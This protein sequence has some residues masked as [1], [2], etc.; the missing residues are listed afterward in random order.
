MKL[1]NNLK[2]CIFPFIAIAVVFFAGCESDHKSSPH[3]P[4]AGMGSIVI[5]NNFDPIM[6]YI[7]GNFIRE[8]PYHN[9]IAIDEAPGNYHVK[10]IAESSTVF[11]VPNYDNNVVPVYEGK[12]TKINVSGTP[13][14]SEGMIVE[15]SIESP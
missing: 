4:A 13:Y 11:D 10:L 8:A 5:N 14:N 2:M 9:D 7:N 15:L 12:I 3:V 1:N 6:V